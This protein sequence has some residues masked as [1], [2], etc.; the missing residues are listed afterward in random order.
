MVVIYLATKDDTSFF[1]EI[2]SNDDNMYWSGHLVEPNYDRIKKIFVEHIQNQFNKLSR[3]V[4]I[5][6]DNIDKIKYGYLYLDPINYDTASVS[7]AVLDKFSGNGIGRIAM[8]RLMEVAFINGYRIL[9]AEIREDNIRSQRLFEAIG[10][11]QTEKFRLMYI[12]NISKEIKMIQYL[13]RIG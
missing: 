7:I 4:Y 12:E 2:K 5:I 10:F 13:N 1:Y 8:K 3:K 9:V 6:S 11:H